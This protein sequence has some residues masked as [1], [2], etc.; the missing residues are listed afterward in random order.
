MAFLNYKKEIERVIQSLDNQ[1]KA[2]E[3]LAKAVL[4]LIEYHNSRAGQTD[5][6]S[7][8]YFRKTPLTSDLTESNN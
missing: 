3:N 1:T 2:I 4:A 6:N 5:H 7:L 8:H